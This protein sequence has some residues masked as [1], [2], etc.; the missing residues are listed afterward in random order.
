MKTKDAISKKRQKLYQEIEFW[1]AR[2]RDVR[3]GLA[4]TPEAQ[5]ARDKA[6]AFCRQE[7]AERRLVAKRLERGTKAQRLAGWR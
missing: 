6:V 7:L 1:E 4:L 2:E 5:A 3:A